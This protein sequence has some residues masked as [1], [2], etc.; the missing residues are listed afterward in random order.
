MKREESGGGKG[1]GELVRVK[2]NT[3]TLYTSLKLDHQ[4][5]KMIL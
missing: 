4:S 2:Y 3:I 5:G 1:P